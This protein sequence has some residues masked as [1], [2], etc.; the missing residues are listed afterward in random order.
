MNW[1]LIMIAFVGSAEKGVALET[2]MFSDQN[3]CLQA[4]SGYVA[5][6]KDKSSA[7]TEA[8]YYCAPTKTINES[9]GK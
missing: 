6:F 8:T 3:A 1:V 7:W 4:G 5:R 2:A 9:M